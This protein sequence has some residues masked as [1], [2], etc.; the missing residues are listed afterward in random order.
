MEAKMKRLMLWTLLA[1]LP[2]PYPAAGGEAQVSFHATQVIDY[3]PGPGNEGYPDP[4][5]ALGGPR[6]AGQHAGS[7]HVV[8][9][10]LAGSVTLGFADAG[11]HVRL[12]TDGAGDDFIVFENAM[13]DRRTG[14]TF[15]EL[16][17]V[18][19]S[20]DGVHFAEFP[21]WCGETF[22]VP[23]SGDDAWIDPQLYSGFAGVEPV[24]ANVASTGPPGQRD[25]FD[26]ADA[27]GDAFDLADLADVPAVLDGLVDPNAIRHLRLVDV[28]GS[29]IEADS[30]GNPIYD[31]SGETD[32]WPDDPDAVR[33]LSADIDAVSVI[34]G[35]VA[36]GPA[37]GDADADGDVDYIDY[38]T[39]KR[40]VGAGPDAEWPDGDFD[41]DGYV[42]WP[43]FLLL[44]DHHGAA[45]R[46]GSH[47][48][49]RLVPEPATG[50]I[51]MMAALGVLCRRRDHG[52]ETR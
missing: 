26:P 10:G 40:N 6:G 21:T 48:T 8:T 12:I 20:S 32:R 31:P 11:G 17:R 15:G 35:L 5:L 16:V 47:T 2:S 46:G 29:G 33:S 18:Q 27:G 44:R 49:G 25:P 13:V 4:A 52:L 38:V 36:P 23:A 39:L 1:A 28:N 41:G 45:Q 19:V 34:H 50:A 42:A 9:L 51:L 14:M 24:L 37:A 43:D 22:Q 30:D 7:D 3:S